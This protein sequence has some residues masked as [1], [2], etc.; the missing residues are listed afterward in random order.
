ML[1]SNSQSYDSIL[2]KCKETFII[3]TKIGPVKKSAETPAFPKTF[4]TLIMLYI[5]VIKF[6]L[7][8]SDIK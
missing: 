1:I 7:N 2:P 6:K 5:Y 4:S 3:F 8:A